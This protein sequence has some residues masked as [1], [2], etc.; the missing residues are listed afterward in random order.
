MPL[1]AP[2]TGIRVLAVDDLSDIAVVH[3][4]AFPESALT[5]LGKEAVRRYYEWQLFGP[6]DVTALG[7]FRDS[8]LIG[9]C[10][11]GI[12]RGAL[13]GFLHK[14]RWFLTWHVITH[15]WLVRNP[16]VRGRLES[17]VT[18]L[19]KK[20]RT[21]HAPQ[22]SDTQSTVRSFGILS[23]AVDPRQQR[24][25]AGRL[26]MEHAERTAR[27]LQF[28]DMALT[29]HPDNVK[30]VRFYERLGWTRVLD[31]GLWNGKMKKL[32]S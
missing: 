24:H 5:S 9:F 26:L 12:F 23:I 29:V 18:I 2:E 31:D 7:A 19:T 16:L 10:V 25:G 27:E 30:A 15:P 13:S 3:Q 1:K 17:A 28:T 22:S 14:N 20:R 11:G 32:V 6:H 8:S 21:P 4:A